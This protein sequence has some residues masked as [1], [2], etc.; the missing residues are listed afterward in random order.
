MKKSILILVSFAALVSCN[1]WLDGTTDSTNLTKTAIWETEES[2]NYYLNGFY[3][4]IQKYG[5]FGEA[6]FGG[7]MIESLTDELKYGSEALGNKAGHP[8]NYV[9][10]VDAVT[11]DGCL[12]GIWGNAYNQ[13]RRVNDFLDSRAKYSHFGAKTDSLFVAQAKFFRAFSACK[14]SSERNYLL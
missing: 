3:T 7:S 2:A 1:K 4:Y 10:N 5:Q 9:T 13:I 8:N 11:P 6:Q 12:W 14:A